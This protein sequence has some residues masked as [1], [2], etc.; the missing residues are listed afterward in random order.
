MSNLKIKYKIKYERLDTQEIRSI[1]MDAGELAWFLWSPTVR[2]WS[3][4][5][6]GLE[7]TA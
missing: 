5:L 3:A 7:R 4:E 2:V 1:E 6:C